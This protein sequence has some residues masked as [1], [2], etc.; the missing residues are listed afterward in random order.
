MNVNGKTLG[1]ISISGSGTAGGGEYDTIKISGS[2]TLSGDTRCNDFRCSG[3]SKIEHTLHTGTGKVSGSAKFMAD[4]NSDYF[5]TSGS[6]TILGNVTTKEF[7]TSG[8]VRIDG[9]MDAELIE[10]SGSLKVGKDC[11]AEE[12]FVSGGC[13][14]GGL[15]NAG[16]IEIKLG[17]R[18]DIG[19]IGTEIITVKTGLGHAVLDFIGSLFN[20]EPFLYTNLIEGDEIY[21]ENTICAMVRGKTVRIGKGCKIDAVEYSGSLEVTDTAQVGTSAQI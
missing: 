3:S 18:C 21:L 19:S 8:S 20:Q 5:S 1:N 7:K 9:T 11:N 16:E 15:L 4:L 6:T 17:G 14:I 10:V 12:F 13:H 2:G